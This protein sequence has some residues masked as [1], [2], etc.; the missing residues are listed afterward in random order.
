M[1]VFRM[2]STVFDSELAADIDMFMSAMSVVAV[3]ICATLVFGVT[4]IEPCVIAPKTTMTAIKAA[5]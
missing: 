2:C 1:T 5:T 4:W 3:A